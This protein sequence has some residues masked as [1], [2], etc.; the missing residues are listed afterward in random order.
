MNQFLKS[1]RTT[2]QKLSY[3]RQQPVE[4]QAPAEQSTADDWL[5]FNHTD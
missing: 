1:H 5:N 4:K 2:T 3:S